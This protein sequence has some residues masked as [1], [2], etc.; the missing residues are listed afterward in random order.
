MM[1]IHNMCCLDYLQH[2]KK[3]WDLCITS[4]PYNMR[5]RIRYGKYCK[6]TDLCHLSNKYDYLSD[7]LSI[8]EFYDFHSKVL[9]C[10]L[11]K[12]DIIFYNIS[13]VT[14]SKRAFFKIIGDFSDYLKDI[15]IWDKP[16]YQPARCEN[17]LNR[18]SEL[19]LIF[20]K[21]NAISRRFKHAHFVRGGLGD[22]WKIGRKKSD[23]HANRATFPIS[24]VNHIIANFA[25]K[26][27]KIIDPF[28]GTGTTGVSAY[29]NNCFFTGIEQ[30][31]QTFDYARQRLINNEKQLKLFGWCNDDVV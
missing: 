25:P 29:N 24:L 13:I 4:P 28:M 31:F 21:N 9:K 15:V 12:V 1:D 23:Y 27:A 5:L 10:L 8:D 17:V 11:Q 14:G 7:D 6:R 19:I 2:T 22:I 20:D 18:G 26:N 16:T 3:T 30:D